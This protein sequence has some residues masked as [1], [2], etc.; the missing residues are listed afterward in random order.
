M[1]DK[2]APVDWKEVF[3]NDSCY[4]CNQGETHTTIYRLKDGE[5]WA[6]SNADFEELREFYENKV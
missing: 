5:K 1:T 3:R 4:G 6:V 2:Q